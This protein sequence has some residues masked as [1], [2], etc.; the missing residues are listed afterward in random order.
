MHTG[1]TVHETNPASAEK[2]RILVPIGRTAAQPQLQAAAE[3]AGSLRADVV[4][5]H[6]LPNPDARREAV[7]RAYLDTLVDHLASKHIQ[8]EAVVLSGRLA[9]TIIA[10]A[11]RLAAAAIVLGVSRRPSLLDAVAR[12]VSAA[13]V[14]GAPCPVLLVKR[15]QRKEAD[16]ALWDF[17]SAAQR[18]GP[19]TRRPPCLRS[20]AVARIVGSIDRSRELGDDFRPRRGARRVVDE[21]RLNAILRALKQGLGLPA[22]E[23]YQ[24]GSGYYVLDGHHRVAAAR[25][26][27]QVEIDANVVEFVPA[28]RLARSRP[29][30]GG[31]SSQAFWRRG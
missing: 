17:E 1:N 5:L 29:P 14:R 6:V 10:E 25:L 21:H 13:V 24:L 8:A 28:G 11:D 31:D 18:A 19:L 30:C 26:L 23:L 3:Y 7:A 9:V 12:G 15:P 22:V 27:G 16:P 20:V 2:K 4:L